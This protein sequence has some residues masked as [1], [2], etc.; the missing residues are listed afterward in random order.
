M[1]KITEIMNTFSKSIYGI[2]ITETTQ[3]ETLEWILNLDPP[4][5]ICSNE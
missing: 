1:Q 4:P 2:N 5:K 3:L